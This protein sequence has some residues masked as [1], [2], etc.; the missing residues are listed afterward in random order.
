[1]IFVSRSRCVGKQLGAP[2]F[3]WG[4]VETCAAPHNTKTDPNHAH[5]YMVVAAQAVLKYPVNLQ[6]SYSLLLL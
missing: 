3:V 5:T 2:F 6:L 4:F 1:M